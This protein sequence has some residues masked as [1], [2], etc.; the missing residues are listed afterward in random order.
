MAVSCGKLTVLIFWQRCLS[1]TLACISLQN[2]ALLSV[3]PWRPAAVWFLS[4]LLEHIKYLA[5]TFLNALKLI[6]RGQVFFKQ[7]ISSKSHHLV[8]LVAHAFNPRT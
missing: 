7:R 3:L 5:A 1:R 8:G 2:I 4:F 6:I